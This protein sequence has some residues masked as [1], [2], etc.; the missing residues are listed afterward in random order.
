M[1]KGFVVPKLDKPEK[2]QE[3]S[4]KYQDDLQLAYFLS[5]L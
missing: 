3:A 2:N 5:K 4:I 1:V